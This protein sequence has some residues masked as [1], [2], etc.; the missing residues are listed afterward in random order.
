MVTVYMHWGRE[1]FLRPHESQT[2][3]AKYLRSIGVSAVIGAH[4][5]VLQGHIIT[6]NYLVAYSIGNFL[7]PRY[8]TKMTV[9]GTTN[10]GFTSLMYMTKWVLSRCVSLFAKIGFRPTY[11]GWLTLSI[12]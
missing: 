9:S 5:H 7:F 8:G 4:P 10:L 3:V 12:T 6:H 2:R 1:F 11:E